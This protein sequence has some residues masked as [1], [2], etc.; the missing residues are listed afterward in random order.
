MARRTSSTPPPEADFTERIVDIDVEEELQG[1]FLEYAYSV[2][3]SRA[4]LEPRM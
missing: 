1:A 4:L 2:I 3:Y